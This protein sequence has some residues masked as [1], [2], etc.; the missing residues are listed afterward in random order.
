[1]NKYKTFIFDCDGVVLNSNKIK[2]EAFYK[3][4]LPYGEEYAQKFKEHH[5]ANGGI[6]RYKKFEYFLA[7]MVPCEKEGLGL[8]E[9]LKIYAAIIEQDLLNCEIAPK[10]KE[11]RDLT[12]N[13]RWVMISGG[14]QMELQEIMHKR[15]ISSFFDGGIF[16]SPNSKEV[17]LKREMEKE[18]IQLP[19]LFL[20]DTKYDYESAK[21][22]DLDFIFLSGWSEFKELREYANKNK[23]KVFESIAEFLEHSINACTP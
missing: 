3:T 20:G 23:I 9:L 17:I 10:L 5:I 2:T 6:S 11:L 21:N 14:D 18:N 12:I 8:N 19:A 13:S 4:V 22:A 16:G 7:N 1:M 15:N